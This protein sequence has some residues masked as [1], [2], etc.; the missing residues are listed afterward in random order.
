MNKVFRAFTAL[1]RHYGDEAFNVGS[2]APFRAL[3]GCI[4]SQRTHDENAS[5]AADALFNVASTPCEILCLD[6]ETLKRLIRPSGYY[7]LKSAYIIGACKGIIE[8]FNS[9]TPRTREGLMTLPGVG[10]KTADIVL[11]YG[12]GVPS[13]AVDTHILRVCKRTGLVSFRA[14]PTEVKDTL[15]GSL[16]RRDWFYT[17]SAFLQLGKE[18]CKPQKPRCNNCP[19]ME[20]CE[21]RKVT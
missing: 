7:N 4:L 12:Y 13:I 1:R 20:L 17:D 19:L 2:E 14:R 3:I 21:Y 5:K 9:E 15:E 10:P 11:S 6:P 16:P 18:Y 8:R